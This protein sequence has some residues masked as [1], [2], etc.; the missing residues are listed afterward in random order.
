MSTIT[1]LIAG[2]YDNYHIGSGGGYVHPE[3]Y[4]EKEYAIT[5]AQEVISTY[6]LEESCVL[7]INTSNGQINTVWEQE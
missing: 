5:K 1:Y 6:D 7:E 4:H 2:D 3:V